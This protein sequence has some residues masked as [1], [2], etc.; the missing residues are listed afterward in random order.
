MRFMDKI[1]VNEILPAA[2]GAVG[3]IYYALQAQ[4]PTPSPS[5]PSY[6][7]EMGDWTKHVQTGQLFAVAALATGVLVSRFE[8]T[9]NLV[10]RFKGSRK[11][12]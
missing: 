12:G 2:I 8:G 5:S 10:S 11:R 6:G 9:R 3:V 1:K 7:K 4:A